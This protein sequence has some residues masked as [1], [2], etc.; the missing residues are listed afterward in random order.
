MPRTTRGPSAYISV[1]NASD[2]IDYYVAVFGAVEDFRL[3]DPA[4]GRIGHAQLTFG[5]QVLM[6]S[7]EFPDFGSLGPD[8]IGGTPVKL[9]IE[10]D[11]ADAV[12]EKALAHGG[13]EMRPVKDQFYGYRGGMVADPFGH[14]WFIQTKVEDVPP[15]VMQER[16]NNGL[17]G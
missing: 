10:V 13:S 1:K 17:A 3:T 2:A 7:D 5:D 16:W 15:D 14:Q 6:I 8:S 12:F 11:D 9:H 4:D